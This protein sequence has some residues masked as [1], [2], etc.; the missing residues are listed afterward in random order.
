MGGVAHG[1][2]MCDLDDG[3]LFTSYLVARHRHRHRH[4]VF[5]V[6]VSIFQSIFLQLVDNLIKGVVL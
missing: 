3:V 2:F 6:F 1:V 4:N 5:A